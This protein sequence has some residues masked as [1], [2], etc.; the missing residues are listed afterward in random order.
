MMFD[1]TAKTNEQVEALLD[2]VKTTFGIEADGGCHEGCATASCTPDFEKVVS[3][4]SEW[5]EFDHCEDGKS[6]RT[7][8]AGEC[9][10][11]DVSMYFQEF[12]NPHH[13]ELIRH[14]VGMKDAEGLGMFL[15]CLLDEKVHMDSFILFD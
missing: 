4:V 5:K 13:L 12:G 15:Q 7:A 10:G 1:T 8:F 11:I 2:A 9:N 6:H 3:Y 14:L